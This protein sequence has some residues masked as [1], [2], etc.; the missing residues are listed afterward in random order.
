M[1]ITKKGK[2]SATGK[3]NRKVSF[4]PLNSPRYSLYYGAERGNTRW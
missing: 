1:E 2:Y 3:N 4:D